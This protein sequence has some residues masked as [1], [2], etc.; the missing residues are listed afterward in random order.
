MQFGA[1]PGDAKAIFHIPDEASIEGM[2]SKATE[3][4]AAPG[5]SMAEDEELRPISSFC[6]V[7][8]ER[9]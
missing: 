3:N 6:G 2:V 8:V 9:A 5:D 1:L 7:D 4:T